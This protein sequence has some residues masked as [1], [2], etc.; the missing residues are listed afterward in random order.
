MPKYENLTPEDKKKLEELVANA[1][2]EALAKFGNPLDENDPRMWTAKERADKGLSAEEQIQLL[3]NDVDAIT[4]TVGKLAKDLF[5]MRMAAMLAE[6]KANPE[7]A[8]E[9]LLANYNDPDKNFGPNGPSGPAYAGSLSDPRISPD[10]IV[11][12]VDGPIRA[13]QVP[14]YKNVPGWT[15][16]PDWAEANC[17]CDAHKAMR[18]AA[19]NKPEDD[20]KFPTGFYL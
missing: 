17:A 7:A 4:L 10:T 1:D 15:P 11:E 6:I 14:G 19:N 8:L 9:K 5:D 16:S 18:A 2:P 20:D 13:D 12:T 3:A